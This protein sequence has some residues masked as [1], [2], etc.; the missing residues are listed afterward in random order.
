MDINRKVIEV[1]VIANR[2]ISSA[3][4]EGLE[5]I[6]IDHF[7]SAAGRKILLQGRTGIMKLFGS[8]KTLVDDPITIIS[9]LVSPDTEGAVVNYIIEEGALD[10]PGRGTVF[11]KKATLVKAHEECQENNPKDV[12][13][14]KAKI[15][16]GLAG[17]CCIVH[18]G[19]GNSI[20]KIGLDTGCGV[21]AITFGTG[22]GLRDKLGLWRITIPAEKELVNLVTTSHDARHLMEIMID[23]GALD[24]PGRGFIY[25]YPVK[26]G[27]INTKTYVGM[28]SQAASVEQI[29]SIIDEIRGGSS[30][31]RREFSSRSGRP[32]KRKY[33]TDLLNCILIC[34]EGRANDLI[35]VA[36]SAGAGGGN[37]TKLK[38]RSAKKD[39]SGKIS[40][41]REMSEMIISRSQIDTIAAALEEHGAFDDKTYGQLFCSPVSRA[42]TYLG[43]G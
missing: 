23:L 9:F 25:L 17:V 20:G 18:K 16:S 33:L 8:G 28:S 38:H 31:R 26:M 14:K 29:V 30:W 3:I 4:I 7:N 12:Q 21:P 1:T 40:P 11:S 5:S 13:A 42:C 15:P 43:H 27:M 19:E 36:K 35:K 41:A 6:G 34:N 32:K 22:T 37:L 10:I 24:Q 2:E 39:E